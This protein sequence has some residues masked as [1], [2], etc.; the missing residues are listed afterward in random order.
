M[1]ATPHS[2]SQ[3]LNLRAMIQTAPKPGF[4]FVAALD[5]I[6]IAL[7]FALNGSQFIF[8]PGA[9]VD[10]ARTSH[11][12]LGRSMPSVVLTVGRNGVFFFENQKIDRSEL[13]GRLEDYISTKGEG[14]ALLLKLDQSLSLKDLFDLMDVART[15]GFARV[16]LAAEE[17]GATPEPFLTP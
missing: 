7:F 10:L 11:P 9:Q 5:L 14:G 12:E 3:P 4:D 13:E 15:A 2:V 6:L 8:A 16:Q 1:T 17:A